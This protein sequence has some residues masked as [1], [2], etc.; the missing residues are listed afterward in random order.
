MITSFFMVSLIG[1]LT[2]LLMVRWG[3]VVGWWEVL[4]EPRGWCGGWWGSGRGRKDSAD[5]EFGW[6]QPKRLSLGRLLGSE[7]NP[8]VKNGSVEGEGVLP[9]LEKA[10][11]EA[12]DA[13]RRH[14]TTNLFEGGDHGEERRVQGSAV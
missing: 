2:F 7:R 14:E 1:V 6:E 8:G 11:P 13:T 3:M 5:D 9:S 10:V 4:R 12:G